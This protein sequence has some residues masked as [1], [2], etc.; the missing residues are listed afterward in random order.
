MKGKIY[1]TCVRSAMYVVVTQCCFNC[2]ESQCCSM[3]RSCI[4]REDNVWREMLEFKV[5]SAG[6]EADQNAQCTMHTVEE[7][8]RLR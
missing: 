3:V 2:F 8:R 4:E 5:I 6:R 7:S 1:T